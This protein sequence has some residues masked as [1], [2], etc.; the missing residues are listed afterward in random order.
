MCITTREGGRNVWWLQD[1]EI[2]KAN[3]G[4]GIDYHTLTLGRGQRPPQKCT[5][6][7]T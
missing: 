3:R 7:S 4:F 2:H 1:Q 5:T 6:P